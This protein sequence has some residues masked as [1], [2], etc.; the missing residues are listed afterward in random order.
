[1]FLATSL[2]D[3]LKRSLS[4][5]DI[6]KINQCKFPYKR[7]PQN[8][9]C[10]HVR[11]ENR[12]FTSSQLAQMNKTEFA[13]KFT[14]PKLKQ[15]WGDKKQV[16]FDLKN[17]KFVV[18]CVSERAKTAKASLKEFLDPDLFEC[19]NPSW[20]ICSKL[21]DKNFK[22]PLKKTL[23]EVNHGLNN[24]KVVPLKE[25]VIEPGI[26]VKYELINDKNC[27]NNSAKMEQ[28]ERKEIERKN[29]ADAKAN[30]QSYW[31]KTEMDRI[32]GEQLP[33]TTERKKHEEPRYYKPYLDPQSLSEYHYE[34]MTQVKKNT[35]IERENLT[36]KIKHEN[37]GCE[38]YKEKIDSLV[39][40]EMYN[41]YKDKF[42]I[43][44]GKKKE[45]TKELKV[46]KWKD[47]ELID[48]IHTIS[49]WKDLKWYKPINIKDNKDHFHTVDN[50]DIDE[51][52]KKELL[53]PLITR[54]LDVF[55]EETSIKDKKMSEYKKKLKIDLMKKKTKPGYQNAKI[56]MKQSKYPL[57]KNLYECQNRINTCEGTKTSPKIDFGETTLVNPLRTHNDK[58]FFL[59][60]Y[61][62]IILLDEDKNKKKRSASNYKRNDLWIE[63]KYYHPG[64]Y[65]SYIYRFM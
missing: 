39:H 58:E 8:P 2:N 4:Q 16:N 46:Y 54:C 12:D 57:D 11:K 42:Q 21:D 25:K 45:K 51:M 40:K 28:D 43:M 10:L 44:I 64:T 59:E 62:N 33:M 53:K 37:P 52:K 32:N 6:D 13:K 7:P 63:Y 14:I 30:T 9:K 20:N 35:W 27:W 17:R 36:E 50:T 60:A 23:F 22:I 26:D 56:T 19:K 1:M 29:K 38:K 34:I 61:K 65:V 55:K 18:D 3:K 15:K 49:N 5:F 41:T 47:S 24:F 48:K 31:F